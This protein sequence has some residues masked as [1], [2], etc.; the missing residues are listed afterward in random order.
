MKTLL[1]VAR[2]LK[3]PKVSGALTSLGWKLW[4]CC[5]TELR[6]KPLR[7]KT[8]LISLHMAG[9]IWR[10][11]HDASRTVFRPI[12]GSNC[13][14][15]PS[16][17]GCCL[18]ID[19]LVSSESTVSQHFPSSFVSNNLI[20]LRA[21]H[22]RMF[23]MRSLLPIRF[24]VVHCPWFFK[25]VLQ[26]SHGLNYW[27]QLIAFPIEI[28][29]FSIVMLRNYVF[30]RCFYDVRSL[31][32][33]PYQIVDRVRGNYSVNLLAALLSSNV[34][35]VTDNPNSGDFRTTLSRLYFHSASWECPILLPSR[36]WRQFRSAIVYYF[37]RD[38]NIV[39]SGAVFACFY[40]TWSNRLAMKCLFLARLFHN[41]HVSFCLIS[42][43]WRCLH[44]PCLRVLLLGLVKYGA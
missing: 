40:R 18:S 32:N 24:S 6:E 23:S 36:K 20:R 35:K 31:D 26:D 14:V 4:N 44:W 9:V 38:G 41:Y 15:F 7:R 33:Q 10:A 37:Y 42:F 34:S 22:Q 12:F 11:L 8:S 30:V 16:F 39:V 3:E 27:H 1:F 21:M 13:V 25:P 43:M 19:P 29:Q 2:G 17:G 5:E 28:A